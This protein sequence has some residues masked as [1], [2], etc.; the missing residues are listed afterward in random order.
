MNKIKSVISVFLSALFIIGTPTISFASSQIF[1]QEQ[2]EYEETHGQINF[3]CLSVL[4]ID[5]KEV[6][7]DV[8]PTISILKKTP[9]KQEKEKFDMYIKE[10]PQ[11]TETLSNM[12]MS[13]ENV[14]VL[15]Y[16]EAPIVK[17][18]E[19]YERIEKD[20]KNPV[21]FLSVSTSAAVKSEGS[22]PSL[23]ANQN[24]GLSTIVT[25]KG[26]SNP[27]LYTALTIGVWDTGISPA[28]TGEN[29]P[30]GGNDFVLQS[31]PTVTSTST[32]ACDY[33][34]KTNGQTTGQEG[35]NFFET[36]GG[37]SWIEFSVEDDPLGLAQ[38]QAFALTQTFRAKAT[39]KTKKIH[40]HYIHTWQ[41]MSLD[42]TASGTAGLQ[43]QDPAVE[44]GL[45]I[46]PSKETKWW[47]LHNSVSYNW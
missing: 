32:F 18:E 31:C 24:F 40:S 16:T 19:H 12:F 6:I 8:D 26:E 21:G 15:S 36:D 2:T 20:T 38:L 30:G 25:R 34:Y 37:D 41:T 9:A 46:T 39:T 42:V 44:V 35:V 27:Y 1:E 17:V 11:I 5:K 43:G 4:V 10:N 7:V 33:N 23:G 14:C 3:D 47:P 28:F 22:E 45:S 29:R 13:G